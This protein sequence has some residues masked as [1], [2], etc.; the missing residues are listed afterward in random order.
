MFYLALHNETSGAID[1][2]SVMHYIQPKWMMLEIS[3]SP[4][5]YL[6]LLKM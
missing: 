2:F 5:N 1:S 4:S 6:L 3:E